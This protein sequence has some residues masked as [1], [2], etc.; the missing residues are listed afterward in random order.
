MIEENKEEGTVTI[1]IDVDDLP[2]GTTSIQLPDGQIIELGDSHTV[3]VTIRTEDL[4]E[5]GAVTIIALDD[6]NTPLGSFDVQV[7]AVSAIS[8]VTEI[9]VG[10][11]TVLLWIVGGLLGAGVIVLAI[12]V[13]WKKK[14]AA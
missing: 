9:G 2:E 12:Y 7:E 6:E 14:K 13:I 5:D 10:F 11:V 4:S 3:Q 1:E 8:A